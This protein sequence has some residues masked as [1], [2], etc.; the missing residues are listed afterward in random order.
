MWTLLLTSELKNLW[1]SKL[2]K[3]VCR[4]HKTSIGSDSDGTRGIVCRY[5]CDT[6]K[7]RHLS[8]STLTNTLD[9]SNSLFHRKHGGILVRDRKLA[10]T[11]V[12]SQNDG[13][14]FSRRKTS[15]RSYVKDVHSHFERTHTDTAGCE[16]NKAVSNLSIFLM[17]VFGVVLFHVAKR[18]KESFC[19][20]DVREEGKEIDG[21]I[22]NYQN[23][24]KIASSTNSSASRYDQRQ[25]ISL[26]EAIKQAKDLCQRVKVVII[27]AASL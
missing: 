23:G 15:W 1:R 14:V 11:K 18:T 13:D 16:K 20:E 3:I 17:T 22:K 12:V 25:H 9:L 2:S 5:S 19:E 24:L 21:E 4:P 8:S 10:S 26:E 27:K 7:P 6:K